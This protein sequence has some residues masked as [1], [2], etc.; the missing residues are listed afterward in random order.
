MVTRSTTVGLSCFNIN[1]P[2]E[3]EQP[4]GRK[5]PLGKVDNVFAFISLATQTTL[6]G[7]AQDLFD[8]L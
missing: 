1:P 8:Q 7:I 6:T 5:I 3:I 4:N 2:A